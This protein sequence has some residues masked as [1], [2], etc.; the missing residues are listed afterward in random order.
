MGVI[1]IIAI[2]LA[3]ILPIIYIISSNSR[4]QESLEENNALAMES[5]AI[6]TSG[7]PATGREKCSIIVKKEEII[8]NNGRQDFLM[9]MRKI[10][11][12]VV[13]QETRSIQNTQYN[14][15]K[16]PSIGKAVVGGALFGPAGAIIGGTS[17]KAKTTSN[18]QVRTE[19]VKLYLTIDYISDN[20]PK[21]IMFEGSPFCRF[22][23]IQ[24]NINVNI[25]NNDIY[26]L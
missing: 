22:Y 23:D 21:Q 18:T 9:P 11:G 5:N 20:I 24:N 4:Y 14:T 13:S 8:I 12:A 19:I 6:H 17:G 15:K 2:I 26:T 3:I 25:S 10:T 1:I 16:S 7:L